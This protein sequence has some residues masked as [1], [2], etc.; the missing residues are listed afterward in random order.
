MAVYCGL[1]QNVSAY[2]WNNAYWVKH[3]STAFRGTTFQVVFKLIA[4][5]SYAY[6]V[7]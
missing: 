7:L 3:Y 4:L 6:F 2:F 5:L 1:M